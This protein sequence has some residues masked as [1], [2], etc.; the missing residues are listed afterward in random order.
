MKTLFTSIISIL[1]ILTTLFTQSCTKEVTTPQINR[2]PKIESLSANPDTVFI[3]GQTTLTC[4][5]TDEDGDNLTIIW[6]SEVGNFPNGFAGTPVNWQAPPTLG[7]YEITAIVSDG[8]VIDSDEI[9]INVVTAPTVTYEGKTYNTVQ[10]GTQWWLKE[11][12]D[13]G[14]RI[15]GVAE[16]TNNGVIEKYCYDDDSANCTTYGGLYQWGEA[17]QYI[18]SEGAQ[19]ICP[20]GW[21]IPSLAEFEILA[22]EV[23]GDGNALKEIGQGKGSGAG[24]NTSGFSVFLVGFRN[25]NGDFDGFGVRTNL[26]SS[27]EHDSNN[28]Y[29]LGLT[30]NISDIVLY[31]TNLGNG[32]CIRCMK[33]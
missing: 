24:T 7:S 14:T 25:L 6:S 19:G 29:Y 23:G 12:L 17:M 33:D 5:A 8:K 4:L 28:D 27:T 32:W 31:F 3:N 9:N 30:D 16:Q 18:K 2:A 21:H 15:D 13:V 20:P 10:I 1:F 11:N 22:A 26:M